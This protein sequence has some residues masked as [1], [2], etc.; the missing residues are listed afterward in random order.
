[1]QLSEE[2]RQGHRASSLRIVWDYGL[3]R[4]AISVFTTFSFEILITCL[5]E[6][7]TGMV[8]ACYLQQSGAHDVT[9]HTSLANCLKN[10][11]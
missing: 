3:Y 4:D 8:A 1:M 5:G 7:R 6:I 2:V 11:F 10:K 9:K